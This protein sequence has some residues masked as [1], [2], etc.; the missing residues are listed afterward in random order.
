MFY[1]YHFPVRFPN[2]VFVAKGTN[3]AKV[4]IE[5]LNRKIEMTEKLDA[6]FS[7]TMKQILS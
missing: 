2:V 1:D 4:K 5:A 3:E 7:K 6:H